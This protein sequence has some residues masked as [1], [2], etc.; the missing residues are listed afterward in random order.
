MSPNLYPG[1]SIESA[2]N[3]ADAECDLQKSPTKL[4]RNCLDMA[5][6]VRTED[7]AR[8]VEKI[9]RTGNPSIKA[10]RGHSNLLLTTIHIVPIND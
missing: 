3:F 4:D 10:K 6:R 9:A 2:S 8:G 5:K 1:P 7:Q